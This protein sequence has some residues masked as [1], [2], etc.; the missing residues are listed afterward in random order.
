[1]GNSRRPRVFLLTLAAAA[2]GFCAAV[3]LCAAIRLTATPDDANAGQTGDMPTELHFS[4]MWDGGLSNR[5]TVETLERQSGQTVPLQIKIWSNGSAGSERGFFRFCD[6]EGYI[7]NSHH[8]KEEFFG[9]EFVVPLLSPDAVQAR[10]YDRYDCQTRV[11]IFDDVLNGNWIS[12][13]PACLTLELSGTYRITKT[14]VFES[15]VYR[16]VRRGD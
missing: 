16:I 2:I 12:D 6:R 14:E 9:R 15:H 5:E 7:F 3:A 8:L 1:M 13:C 10:D 4:L 11:V